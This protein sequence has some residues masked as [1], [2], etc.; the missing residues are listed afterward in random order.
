MILKWLNGNIQ[1]HSVRSNL[2]KAKEKI[3]DTDS[4]RRLNCNILVIYPFSAYLILQKFQNHFIL[5]IFLFKKHEYDMLFR[6]SLQNT[7][8]YLN[9][10]GRTTVSLT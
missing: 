9:T 8:C 10:Y 5:G 1:Q 6:H 4:I 2:S 3:I 7:I